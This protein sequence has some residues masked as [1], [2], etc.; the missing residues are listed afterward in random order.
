M[1]FSSNKVKRILTREPATDNNSK[2]LDI[3][4]NNTTSIISEMTPKQFEKT[5]PDRMRQVKATMHDSNRVYEHDIQLTA[6]DFTFEIENLETKLQSKHLTSGQRKSIIKERND[7]QAQG[8]DV[9]IQKSTNTRFVDVLNV[10]Q[11]KLADVTKLPPGLKFD[12][13]T[14]NNMRYEIPIDE[15]CNSFKVSFSTAEKIL[16]NTGDTL[17]KMLVRYSNKKVKDQLIKGWFRIL[18]GMERRKNVYHFIFTPQFIYLM[19][20]G[21][22]NS[23]RR[24]AL[25]VFDYDAKEYKFM[26][27]LRNFLESR[28]YYNE[29]NN[30]E[31]QRIKLRNVLPIFYNANIEKNPKKDFFEPLKQHLAK[32]QECG[33]FACAFTGP[34]GAPLQKEHYD[35]LGVDINGQLIT[36]EEP[37]EQPKTPR[38]KVNDLL[39]NVYLSYTYFERP[40]RHITATTKK[41]RRNA[42]K[43]ANKAKLKKG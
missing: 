11:T 20:L 39:D 10:L 21:G 32:L 5:A 6:T 35:Y 38:V 27:Q 8:L 26:G 1:D 34:K 31:I 15:I 25:L 17:Q 13:I 24:P 28:F 40:E 7:L 18:A 41:Y 43:A 37:G 19:S 3:L 4:Q 22:K 23:S 36:D 2:Y 42:K 14:A 9:L 29:L 16:D 30:G 33:L 12:E